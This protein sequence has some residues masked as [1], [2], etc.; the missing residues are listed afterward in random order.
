M[1][2]IFSLVCAALTSLLS[3]TAPVPNACAEDVPAFLQ[4]PQYADLFVTPARL[5][6]RQ[7]GQWYAAPQ[8]PSTATAAEAAAAVAK[9]A[10]A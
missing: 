10:A 4:E 2:C 6:T 9:A 1:A 8:R 5:I 7:P 3:S